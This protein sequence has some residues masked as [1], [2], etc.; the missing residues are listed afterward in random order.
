MSYEVDALTAAAQQ[1]VADARRLGLTWTLQN[2]TVTATSPVKVQ[3]DGDNVSILVTSMIG[4][5]GLG[6]RVYVIQVPP[7]GNFVVGYI[8]DTKIPGL[9]GNWTPMT[10][11]NGW[12]NSGGVQVPAQYRLVSS[13]PNSLQ[14]VG[15]I[16]AG[17]IT[18]GTII[19]NLPDGYRPDHS[20]SFPMGVNPTNRAGLMR[21]EPGGNIVIFGLTAGT[22]TIYFNTII[23][24]DA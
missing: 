11:L 14:I 7:A 10:L 2:A 5:V 6:L 1:V 12:T 20:V 21:E 18:D 17:T 3:M 24:L 15:D 9:G 22:T 23:P 8:G 13:P 19:T 16:A 4:P